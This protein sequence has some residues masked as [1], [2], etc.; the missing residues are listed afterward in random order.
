MFFLHFFT[1]FLTLF[2][3]IQFFFYRWKMWWTKGVFPLCLLRGAHI[4]Q[5]VALRFGDL[6]TESTQASVV[7]LKQRKSMVKRLTKHDI[8]LH[9]SILSCSVISDIEKIWNKSNTNQNFEKKQDDQRIP[10]LGQSGLE[11]NELQG[12][13]DI[14]QEYIIAFV[15]GPRDVVRLKPAEV[16][17]TTLGTLGT[18][19]LSAARIPLTLTGEACAP[20]GTGTYEVFE[21][22]LD[23]LYLSTC[24]L[25]VYTSKTEGAFLVAFRCWPSFLGS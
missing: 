12:L 23:A 6:K 4:V 10:E 14:S 3:K 7:C 18:N 11:A 1:F 20:K 9:Y 22:K 13:N 8:S 17:H 15:R 25:I 5:A 2:P 19:T 21:H 16:A 24:K